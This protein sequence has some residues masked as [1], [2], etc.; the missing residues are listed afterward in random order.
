MCLCGC[1]VGI[2]VPER[3]AEVWENQGMLEIEYDADAVPAMDRVHLTDMADNIRQWRDCILARHPAD[4]ARVENIIKT[5]DAWSRSMG[6]A[7]GIVT[8]AE[9][10]E[11]N[12]FRHQSEQLLNCVNFARTLKA[13]PAKLATAM[14]RAIQ[15]AVPTFIVKSLDG[16]RHDDTG[17]DVLPSATTVRRGQFALD[18]AQTLMRILFLPFILETLPRSP[19]HPWRVD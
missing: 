19:A 5:M 9:L 14:T 8:H 10:A 15:C 2:P 1:S 18:M 17:K 13:G 11:M 16:F 3:G 12:Y 4:D 7:N 6:R